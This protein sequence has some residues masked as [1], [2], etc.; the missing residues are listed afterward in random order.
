MCN[1]DTQLTKQTVVDITHHGTLI[2]LSMILFS[3][4]M[5]PCLWSLLAGISISIFSTASILATSIVCRP[6]FFFF[7]NRGR[8]RMITFSCYLNCIFSC[9]NPSQ[10]YNA[11]QFIPLHFSN[12]LNKGHNQ[13]KWEQTLSENRNGNL[14]EPY[15]SFEGQNIKLTYCLSLF[16]FKKKQ[17]SFQFLWM[18]KLGKLAYGSRVNIQKDSVLSL[19][20]V[21]LFQFFFYFWR[22]RWITQWHLMWWLN[23]KPSPWFSYLDLK[24]FLVILNFLLKFYIVFYE[25]TNWMFSNANVKIEVDDFFVWNCQFYKATLYTYLSTVFI[26]F[27]FSFS[28]NDD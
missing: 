27:C 23:S 4:G 9:N 24:H 19:M 1:P 5:E 18:I 11:L 14:I 15:R 8:P 16:I 21:S 12:V 6:R 22:Q 17:T 7:L 3:F 13:L 25:F 26:S 10:K 2:S 20:A 28:F